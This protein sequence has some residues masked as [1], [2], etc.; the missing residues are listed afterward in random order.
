MNK[1]W[2]GIII[3]SLIYGICTGRGNKLAEVILEVPKETL[4]LSITVIGSALMWGGFMKVM[5]DSGVISKLSKL[6]RPLMKLIFPKLKDEKALNYI[7]FLKK[8]NYS[9]D[10]VT[11]A[12]MIYHMENDR[13]AYFTQ[14]LELLWWLN[15]FASVLIIGLIVNYTKTNGSRTFDILLHGRKTIF[16]CADYC[17]KLVY[18]CRYKIPVRIC[19]KRRMLHDLREQIFDSRVVFNGIRHRPHIRHRRKAHVFRST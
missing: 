5:E 14:N 9:Y 1:L 8:N 6:L 11:E 4:T 18:F 7:D 16:F 17:D 13:R 3:F 10:E 2:A 19:R 12:T 15:V